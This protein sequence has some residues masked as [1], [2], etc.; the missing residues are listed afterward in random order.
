[1]T[2]KPDI[3]KTAQALGCLPGRQSGGR[4]VGGR[5]PAQHGSENGRCFNIWEE[6]QS[7]YCF[8]CKAGGDAFDLIKLV[9]HCDFKDAVYWA[10]EHGLVSGNGDYEASY[11]ELRKLHHI[12]TDA[13]K[14]FHA[15]LKDYSHLKKHYGLTEGTIKQ[16]LI[17]YAPLDKNALKRHLTALNHK[18][19]DIKK[20]GLLGKF[21]DS[22]FQGQYIFPYWHNGLVKYFIGR[23]TPKTPDFKHSK[24]EKLPVTDLIKNDIFYGE[25]SI[26]GKDTVYLTEGV[27]DCLA[28]LQH[29]LPS[30]SPVTVQFKKSDHPKLLALAKGKR[31]FVVPDN[32]LNE[33]GMK[34]AQETLAFLKSNGVQASIITLPRPETQTKIDLNE[35]LRDHGIDAFNR[36]VEEQSPPTIADI[37]CDVGIFTSIKFPEKRTIIDPWLSENSIN[38]IYG[39]RGVGKTM[40]AFGVLCAAVTGEPFGNWQV[41][42]PV[43]SLY[44]DGEMPAPDTQK[45]L[46]RFSS[47]KTPDRQRLI[48]Y[49]DAQMNQY[50]LPRANLL[51]EDWR[52]MMKQLLISNDI[53]LWV[54]DNLASL[55]PGIDENSKQ[56]WDPVNQWFL[57]LRFAGV[58]SIFLHHAN[59]DGGQ[60]GTSGRE[61]N[62]DIS[63]LLD[64]PKNYSPED[65]AR[66]IVKFQ[67]ARIEHKYLPLITDTEFALETD[68]EEN[69]FWT[70]GA[71][72]KQN[73]VQTLTMLDDGIKA[74]DIA[75]EL[76]IDRSRVSQIKRQAIKDGLITE[77][78]KLTQTGFAYVH[79]N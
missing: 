74:A 78:G 38:M 45:R 28:A 1:M 8:H 15:N 75:A 19:V 10:K 34:G 35:Y 72:K 48:I 33:A 55:A 17:G 67:K 24:Y 2:E 66:F 68:E 77:K 41:K 70:F 52:K 23:Q 58:T 47:L 9:H 27:T 60:R 65:G 40:F 31:V 39:P 46:A 54:A 56:E 5:C 6:T 4:Y 49:S 14:F 73:K 69:Y 29:G 76:G 36:L 64:K 51:D 43:P 71:V 30:I 50:G 18:I 59:K 42:T 61:D 37:I 62:L 79:K 12:L 11:H 32:E 21:D 63:I 3:I 53:K 7:F 25:D 26:K 57:E 20:T 44:L 22:F 13:A 16:Y